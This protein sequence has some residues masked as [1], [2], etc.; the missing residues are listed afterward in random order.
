LVAASS[1]FAIRD[2]GLQDEWVVT[3][4]DEHENASIPD[5]AVDE[6][7]E[8]LYVF[9][10]RGFPEYRG[11]IEKYDYEGNPVPFGGSK[12]YIS[13]N[14]ITGNPGSPGGTFEAGFAGS[15]IAVDNSGG[16]HDGEI[17]IVNGGSGSFSG[18]ENIS[19]FRASGVYAGAIEQPE[20]IGGNS[21]DVD[22]GPDGSVYFL[23]T[24]RI[25]KYNAGYNEVGR[26]Y[27]TGAETFTQGNRVVAD[28]KGAIWNV[29]NGPVKFE[30]DQMFTNFTPALG[31]NVATFTGKRSPYVPFPLESG[32]GGG[33]HIA[34]DPGTSRDDLYVNAGDRVEVFSEGT[35][36]HPAYRDAPIFG[37]NVV[38]GSAITVTKGNDVFTG[39]LDNTYPIDLKILRFGPGEIL[40]D[41]FTQASD[42]EKVTHDGGELT[43]EVDLD[44]GTAVVS[45]QVEVGTEKNSYSVTSAPCTPSS[46]GS[47]SA[48]SADVSG[49]TMGTEYHYRFSATNEKGTNFGGDRTFTPAY[50][51]KVKTLSATGIEEDGATLRGQLDPDGKNTEYFFEY[52]VSTSY[53]QKSAKV[54]AGSTPGLQTVTAPI[55]GLPLGKVFHYRI[56]TSNVDGTT[57]G[58]DLTFRTASTPSVYG[59]GATNLT[60]TSA[61]L[62]ATIDPVGYPTKYRFEYGTSSGYGK[63]IPIPD[64]AIPTVNEPVAVEQTV[65]G[66]TPGVTYHYRVVATSEPWGASFSPDTT[67]DFSPP[68]CPN[69]HSRQETGATFLPDCRGYE[70]VSP[71]AAGPVQLMPGQIAFELNASPQDPLQEKFVWPLNN[72]LSSSPPRMMF[73][74]F[75]GTVNGLRAPNLLV[76]DSYL[77]TRTSSGWKTTLPGLDD[78]FG[79][80]SLKECSDT[81]NRCLEYNSVPVPLSG[82]ILES[83]PYVYTAEG[84][85]LERLPQNANLV[86][87]AN[88]YKGF[89]RTSP[90]FSN[91]VFS[92]RETLGIFG[93]LTPGVVFTV[94]GQTTGAGSAYDN[95]LE[96]R[97]VNLISRLPGTLGGGHIPQNGK[98][99]RPIQF[100][101]ISGDGSHVLMLTEGGFDETRSPAGPPYH[102]YMR[103]NDA[104]SYDVSKGGA[105][106]F[107]GMTRDG[108][109]VTFTSDE[110]LNGE[111]EDSSVDLYRWEESTDSLT[112]LSVGNGAGNEDD[113]EATWTSGCD[114]E[115]PDTERRWA[116]E[117]EIPSGNPGVPN[118]QGQGL[119]DMIAEH[120]GDVYFYSPESLDG[121]KFGLANERN[122]YVARRNGQVQL[123]GILDP[124]TQ[125][126]RMTI[127]RDGRF[128]AFLTDSQMTSYD[129][130]GFRQVYTYERDSGILVCASCRPGEPPANDVTVSQGGKFMA[131]DGR[132][133]FATKDSLVPRD[134]NGAITDTYE[135]AGGRP[136]LVS[137]G[138][139]SRDFTGEAEIFALFQAPATTGLEAVSRDGIDVYF[140][141]FDTMVDQDNNGLFVKFYDARTNGGFA[142]PPVDEPCDAADE[143]HG[144][145]SS[146]PTPPIIS[147][148]VDLGD[149]G[150]LKQPSNKSSKKDK[151]KKKSKKKKKKHQRRGGRSNG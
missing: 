69:D 106:E 46:F 149:T 55:E 18:T 96:N 77:A 56:V 148:G 82:E 68:T 49:L 129:N 92:S 108:S 58:E 107:V 37:Q 64:A 100:P 34:V 17:Y 144:V 63:S 138:L 43:G 27:T 71:G 124:G 136:Q 127:A 35:A 85:F 20:F 112:L 95:D 102:L 88:E 70:L 67:F 115:V 87:G 125:I 78:D 135:Y 93:G 11:I 13:G 120:S 32:L 89:R 38:G 15:H 83:E 116:G 91:Y 110:Q 59:L 4:C 111:D 2:H 53:G 73:Y 42:V 9:C 7:D 33:V 132:T 137:S 39:S 12:P 151:V 10:E 101:G 24:T 118:F 6:D 147:S 133:F 45:C 52:G 23:T 130:K 134:K 40:P 90:D 113:C 30:P 22:V 139:A 76:P 114:I 123:V 72:G 21:Q 121:S 75:L 86:P 36:T 140:S 142:Q 44:G 146:P 79:V 98:S 65:T 41:V 3:K 104:V 128:A 31:S 1:A 28:N 122:L 62:H 26:M 5:I 50:V 81:K 103:V 97:T 8:V 51:L 145:D 109:S 141:T 14:E 47:D 29:Q 84:K 143:C 25:A 48:V 131:D 57:V 126:Y 61:T 60:G 80:P 119:D 74:G 117:F 54:G 94:D 19:I 16:P 105:T 66:L 99:V 150:N